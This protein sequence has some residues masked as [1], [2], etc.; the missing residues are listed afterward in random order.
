MIHSHC[1]CRRRWFDPW[2]GKIPLQMGMAPH[3]STLAW[4]I[5]WTEEPGGLQPMVLQRVE[6]DQATIKKPS[7]LTMN[8]AD[9]YQLFTEKKYS[10]GTVCWC[11]PS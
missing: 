6:R 4:K 5:P 7:A 1:E 2:V 3:S 10:S 11:D 9:L 8:E